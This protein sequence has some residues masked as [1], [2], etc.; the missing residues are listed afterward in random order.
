MMIITIIIIIIAIMITTIVVAAPSPPGR[1]GGS[2]PARGSTGLGSTGD[3]FS[4][5]QAAASHIASHRSQQHNTMRMRST[6]RQGQ[7][8]L[9]GDL[10]D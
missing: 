6:L 2:P 4:L 5:S 8:S 7:H 1:P 9:A 3:L 10:F